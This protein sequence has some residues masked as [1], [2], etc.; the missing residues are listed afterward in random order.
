VIESGLMLRPSFR[1]KQ[2]RTPKTVQKESTESSFK[3][4]WIAVCL[5]L[6]ALYIIYNLSEKEEVSFSQESTEDFVPVDNCEW[7]DD[8]LPGKCT[9]LDEVKDAKITSAES[10]SRY[11]CERDECKTWQYHRGVC[12][13]GDHSRL[14]GEQYEFGSYP[15]Y[16]MPFPPRPW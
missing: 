15:N 1:T 10:C 7:R 9:G 14:G 6:I 16:C 4:W 12:Y 3:F 8:E 11:C 13:A 5:I 2:K